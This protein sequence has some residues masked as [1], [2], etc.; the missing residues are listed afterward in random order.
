[1]KPSSSFDGIM[2]EETR[3][4]FGKILATKETLLINE[5]NKII[6]DLKKNKIIFSEIGNI[7]Y[8]HNKIKVL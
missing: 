7:S 3:E 2:V 8:C 4:T 5:K 1:M 6:Q